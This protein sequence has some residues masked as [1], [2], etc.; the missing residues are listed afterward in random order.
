MSKVGEL[1]L[2]HLSEPVSSGAVYEHTT[3]VSR[4]P[5]STL[6]REFEIFGEVVAG[7]KVADFGC[8]E[9][10]QSIALANRYGCE[11]V[12]IENNSARRQTAQLAASSAN[13]SPSQ[14]GFVDKPTEDMRGQFDIVISHDSFEHFDNPGAVLRQLTGLLKESGRLFITFGPPWLSP[15]GSH[16][17]FFCRVPWI[18]VLF[19]ESTV[20]N[21]RK[22]YR[23]DGATRYEDVEQGLNKMTVRKFEKLVTTNDMRIE[24]LRYTCILGMN[25]LSRVPLLREFFINHVSIILTPEQASQNETLSKVA[26]QPRAH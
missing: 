15:Y 12:G 11:V 20:L 3:A 23:N 21:V 1:V 9:G 17:Y 18:N 6:E 13:L 16:M 25:A 4:D 8:G 22:L 10:H 26:R 5:L 24:F 2:R 7:R 14:I 19:S